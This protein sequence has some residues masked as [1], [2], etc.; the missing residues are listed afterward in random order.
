MTMIYCNPKKRRSEQDSQKIPV[1]TQKNSFNY[2]LVLDTQLI[3]IQT[4]CATYNIFNE[5]IEAWAQ[6]E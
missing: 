2:S 3:E 5:K 6:R 4:G 1:Y